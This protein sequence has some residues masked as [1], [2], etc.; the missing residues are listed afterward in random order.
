MVWLARNLVGMEH[1]TCGLESGDHVSKD[2][3]VRKLAVF[4]GE[5]EMVSLSVKDHAYIQ[6][7]D[8]FQRNYVKTDE[9]LSSCRE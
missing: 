8:K 5:I 9:L 3:F 2:H 1:A 4:K 6:R 7:R